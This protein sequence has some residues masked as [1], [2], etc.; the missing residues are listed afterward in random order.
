MIFVSNSILNIKFKLSKTNNSTFQNVAYN[1]FVI[2]SDLAIGVM[3]VLTFAPTVETIVAKI[4]PTSAKTVSV[5]GMPI[6]ANNIQNVR[7]PTVTG[8]MFP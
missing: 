6:D 3:I 5:K 2:E 4:T 1:I 7:P 8:A